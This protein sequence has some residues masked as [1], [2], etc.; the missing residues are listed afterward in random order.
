MFPQRPAEGPN[1]PSK[2]IKVGADR[3]TGGGR[4]ELL[5]RQWQSWGAVGRNVLGW[6]G[7]ASKGGEMGADATGLSGCRGELG[8][9]QRPQQSHRGFFKIQSAVW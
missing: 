5:G 3:Q 6:G 2:S 7:G 8:F 9:I 4:E 1:E